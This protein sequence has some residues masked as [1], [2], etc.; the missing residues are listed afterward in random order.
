MEETDVVAADELRR[1]AGWNQRREDWQQLL[2]LEPVGCF[3]AMRNGQL[4]GTVTT[5]AY[6]QALAWIGMMLVHPEHRRQGIATALM[7]R[8]LSHLRDSGVRCVRLDATPAGQ[9]LYE[10]LGFA[11]EWR[12]TRWRRPPARRPLLPE[13]V[14]T[15]REMSEQDWPSVEKIDAAAVGVPRPRLLRLLATGSY[16]ALVWPA[17]GQI[18]GWGLLRPGAESR[19]IGPLVCTEPTAAICL[20]ED[21]LL[22]PGEFSVIWDAP[23]QN[24][25]ATA[26][27][28]RL[29]F[30]A[31]RNLTRMRLGTALSA[32]VP[33]A[34]AAIADPAVG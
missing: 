30:T 13:H 12:I 6:G 23:E 2:R 11:P 26:T 14:A 4:V 24:E 27:V 9:P 34:T 31:L 18:K 10:R 5:T 28:G 3:V 20:A 33:Q 1:L 22:V 16:A 17:Q 25:I 8:A 21:L 32:T 7:R 15:T 19:C 29:G